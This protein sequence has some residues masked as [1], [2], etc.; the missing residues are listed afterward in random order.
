MNNL[1]ARLWLGNMLIEALGKDDDP[2]APAAIE[3]LKEQVETLEQMVEEGDTGEPRN[4]VVK[5][6][7]LSLSAEAPGLGD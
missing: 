5:L 1:Q 6:K 4:V 2:R 7:A 3:R